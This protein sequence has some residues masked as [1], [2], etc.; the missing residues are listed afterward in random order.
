MRVQNL[1]SKSRSHCHSDFLKNNQSLWLNISES[2]QN[3]KI[4]HKYHI[5][6]VHG[7]GKQ[8]AINL[9]VKHL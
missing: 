2:Y 6:L 9:K 1:K 3:V 8:R 5:S 4:N 7:S